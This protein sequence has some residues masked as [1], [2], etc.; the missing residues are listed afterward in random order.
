MSSLGCRN[1]ATKRKNLDVFLC[2]R[3]K[4][5]FPYAFINKAV[6]AKEAI[7]SVVVI[8]IK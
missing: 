6:K 3:R 5:F 4:V 7:K 1:F 2:I 8:R